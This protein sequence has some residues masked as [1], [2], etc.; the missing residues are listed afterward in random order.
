MLFSIENQ[1]NGID[2]DFEE[3]SGTIEHILPENGN[4]HYLEEFPQAI[5]DSIVYRLG[6]YTIL[7]EAKNRECSD[8]AFADKKDIYSISQ[9]E[10]T[11][12][13][14]NPHWTPN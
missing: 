13:I 11:E 7:E 12:G 2:Y 14:T 8:L 6:N 4:Q 3:N 5:H 1:L 9:Y 10:M